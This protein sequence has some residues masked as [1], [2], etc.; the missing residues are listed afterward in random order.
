MPKLNL[1]F[2]LI[3]IHIRGQMQYRASF[4]FEAFTTALV[5]AVS[6]MTIALVL[7]RFEG[8]GGWSL[9]EVAFLYGMVE[10]AFGMM[11]M[12]FSGFDPG[13]FGAQVR[14]GAFDQMLL[15]PIG[16]TLQVLGSEF[17]LR[18]TGRVL[19]GALVLAIALSTLDIHWTLAKLLYLPVVF[20]STVA[21]FGGLFVI[22]ATITFW[23]VESIEVVNIFTYGG[24][25]LITYPMHIY[26]DW[27]RNFF[28][29]IIPAAFLNYYPALYLLGRPDPF[30][31]PA[32][33]PF[34]APLAGFGMLAAGL[35]FWQFGIRHYQS[36]GT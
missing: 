13:N 7:Q 27:M 17:L 11:D 1:Y 31:L 23:T 33:A 36:T 3:S 16:I 25:E 34:L 14:L 24:T 10:S 18:R 9:A 8:I 28:T 21:F 19:Q 26:P 6:F 5:S 35:A 30:H 20:L 4:V 12:L 32:F 2:R 29:F 22:G 15:R